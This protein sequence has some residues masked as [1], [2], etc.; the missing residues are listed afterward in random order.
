M[1]DLPS[2]YKQDFNDAKQQIDRPYGTDH[3]RLFCY[4]Q[5]VPT[6]L[7]TC[8]DRNDFSFPQLI[9][10]NIIRLLVKQFQLNHNKANSVP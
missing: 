6:G 3:L 8:Q 1:C 2:K 9:C 7:I 10:W 5:N 4:Q